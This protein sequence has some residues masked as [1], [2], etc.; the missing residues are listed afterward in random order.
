MNTQ[1]QMK[2]SEEKLSKIIEFD[3]K[4]LKEKEKLLR[5]NA[6]LVEA[7]KNL[8]AEFDVHHSE[9]NFHKNKAKQALAKA[10]AK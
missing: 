9:Y 10:E 7:L 2:I 3:I 6:E 8:L 5:I 1:T 4:N